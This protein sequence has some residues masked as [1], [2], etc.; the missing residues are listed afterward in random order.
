MDLFKKYIHEL[1]Q[2]PTYHEDVIV[3]RKCDAVLDQLN[4]VF[5]PYRDRHGRRVYIHRVG[6]W[7]PSAMPFVEGYAATYKV[8]ELMA[9]EPR[10]QIAGLTVIV[11]AAGFGYR[12]FSSISID[13]LRAIMTFIQVRKTEP[14]TGSYVLQGFPKTLSEK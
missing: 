5:L 13:N 7:D 9:V 3:P 10:T 14:H 1:N 8:L 6:Q 2:R 11:D 12:Q 4:H